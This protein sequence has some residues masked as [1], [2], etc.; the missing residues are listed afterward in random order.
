M[1]LIGPIE[2]E[3]DDLGVWTWL[4]FQCAG[5]GRLRLALLCEPLENAIELKNPASVVHMV[6]MKYALE[7]PLSYW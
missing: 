7:S 2:F 6:I 4:Q 3:P 1:G 5:A